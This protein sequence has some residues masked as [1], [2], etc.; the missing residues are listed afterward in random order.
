MNRIANFI[1]IGTLV[2]LLTSFLYPFYRIWGHVDPLFFY[3]YY[4]LS[5]YDIILL[6]AIILVFLFLPLKTSYKLNLIFAGISI[7]IGIFL[8]EICLF[9]NLDTTLRNLVKQ[10][11]KNKTSRMPPQKA[12]KPVVFDKRNRLDVIRE[13]RNEGIH[14]TLNILPKHLMYNVLRSEGQ[15][16]LPLAGVSGSVRVLC[17]ESGTWGIYENDEHGFNNPQG[18]FSAIRPEIVLIGDSFAYGAC[19]AQKDSIA[20]QLRRAGYTLINLGNS[21]NGPLFELAGIKEYGEHLKPQK[22][23]WLYFERNDLMNLLYEQRSSFL[24]QYMD[25]SFSQHLINRQPEIDRVLGDHLESNYKQ[26]LRKEINKQKS[27]NDPKQKLNS[28]PIPKLS[29]QSIRDIVLLRESRH[30]LG[31]PAINYERSVFPLFVQILKNS[32]DLIST[33]GGELIF[34]YLPSGDSYFEY[35]K[36]NI[37]HR[38]KVIAALRDLDIPIVDVYPS[39]Q[40]HADVLSLFGGRNRYN[41]YSVK[42]YTLVSEMMKNFLKFHAA[43]V[44]D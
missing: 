4:I 11:M 16:I 37:Y 28:D 10:D 13:L 7:L 20:G 43:S 24:F 2:I 30:K 35:A 23:F 26:V 41:H 40:Q 21:G 9:Y 33:W 25:S 1:L 27:D 22:V 31:I 15:K 42:G 8:L 17:N 44:G 19:V 39:F 32:R 3:K 12:E 38:E 14:T 6:S 29:P 18:L 36:K 34:V 5:I